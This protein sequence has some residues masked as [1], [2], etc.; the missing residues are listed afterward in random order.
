MKSLIVLLILVIELVYISTQNYYKVSSSNYTDDKKNRI[1]GSLSYSKSDFNIDEYKIDPIRNKN[2]DIIKELSLDVRLECNDILHVRI[3]DQYKLRWEPPFLRDPSYLAQIDSCEGDRTLDD[4]GFRLGNG[5]SDFNMT[6]THPTT[7]E[8]LYSWA[9]NKFF[10]SDNL[11]VFQSFLT[12]SNIYGFGER[13]HKFKLNDGIYTTWSNDTSNEM[14]TQEGGHA[15]YGIQP[16]G[17]HRTANGTFVGIFFFNINAQDLVIKTLAPTKVSLEH[18]TLGGNIDLYL[19]YG[20]TPEEVIKKY[21]RI[22]GK[23]ALP[24]YWS[25][26][27]Q[28]CRFGYRT[29]EQWIDVINK[30][31]FYR[32]PLD[33]MYTDIDYMEDYRDFTVSQ[34]RY[35]NLSDYVEILL[36]DRDRRYIPIIDIGI[37]L[38]NTDPFYKQGKDQNVFIKSNFT[39]TDLVHEVWPGKTVFPD[40]FHP[41]VS[42]FWSD[43]LAAL[44]GQLNYDALWED[45]NEPS[46]SWD[47]IGVGEL[48][49]VYNKT[50]DAYADIPYYTGN[51]LDIVT[52][53]LSINALYYGYSDKTPYMTHYNLKGMTSF[54]QSLNTYTYLYQKGKRPFIL[55]RGNIVGLGRYAIHWLGDNDSTYEYMKL[56]LSGVFNY[57]MF[58]FSM[59]GS[60]ICGYRFNATD[61]LCAR[62]HVL[63]SFYPF[64]RNHNGRDTVSQEPYSLGNY[65]LTSTKRALALRYSLIRYLYTQL[66]LVSL[67]GG[68]V[69]KPLFFEF[70]NDNNLFEYIDESFMFGNAFIMTPVFTD[71]EIDFKVYYPNASLNQFGGAYDRITQYDP[72][73]KDGLNVTLSGS[74][75]HI[76]L[77]MRGGHIVTR[78]ETV[79]PLVLTTNQ[80][81]R[82]GTEI[83]V[84]P[85]TDWTAY[86]E[87]IF[88][89]GYNND[90][91]VNKDYLH[92][93]MV[94]R[95]NQ[96][97]FVKQNELKSQ[98]QYHDINITKIIFIKSP[99][100][101]DET[102]RV[103]IKL[104]N[105]D[106]IKIWT[107]I[108]ND[109]VIIDLTDKN[110]TFMNIKNIVWDTEFV[111]EL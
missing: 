1:L 70:P 41:N 61:K 97:L 74:F 89:D 59:M 26:G 30:Y 101:H 17:L 99:Y 63:G 78:Q 6:L 13:A 47:V 105:E 33:V 23:S 64:S 102:K 9:D 25:L 58:G 11:I 51:H 69:F 12:S 79:K 36:H 109:N 40:W 48:D 19:F 52:R 60:D 27:W 45:M 10:F 104:T 75:D 85:E 54:M 55:S 28:Q 108:E 57:Q 22:I 39:K 29:Q 91:I 2:F 49:F 56:S 67:N 68:T 98:Y 92:I 96:L 43:G 53:Q 111:K 35:A 84:N 15:L 76:H 8:V 16:F 65:T 90:V 107:T 5:S 73:N 83:I 82:I 31:D 110:I 94:F 77:Y 34:T 14:D 93:T 42:R 106:F 20:D 32:I 21:H 103:T 50:N 37:P 95:Y 7:G 80:L 62:W 4:F 24:P 38:N 44:N 86:G 46:G 100:L 88:D 87:V 72:N 3:T 18:R 81:R 66:F 71:D